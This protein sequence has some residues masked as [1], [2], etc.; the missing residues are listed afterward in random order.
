MTAR[1]NS[2]SSPARLEGASAPRADRPVP[3]GRLEI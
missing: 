3:G 2:T 1:E